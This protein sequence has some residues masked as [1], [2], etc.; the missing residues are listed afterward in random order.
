VEKIIVFARVSDLIADGKSAAI[1][2]RERAQRGGSAK[3]YARTQWFFRTPH[4]SKPD[5][6]NLR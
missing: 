6:H 2:Q 3:A 4:S 5:K 1:R